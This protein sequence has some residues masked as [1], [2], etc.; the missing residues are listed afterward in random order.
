MVKIS[1]TLGNQDQANG[2][3]NN[4]GD[5]GDIITFNPLTLGNFYYID[6]TGNQ[7]DNGLI[8]ISNY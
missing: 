4:G 2:V 1:P 3:T 5:L 7:L 8:T 6:N